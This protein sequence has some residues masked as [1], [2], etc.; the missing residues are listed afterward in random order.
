M[1]KA[2]AASLVFISISMGGFSQ[3]VGIGTA[4]PVNKLDVVS[5]A[6]ASTNASIHSTNTGISGNAVLGVSN[7]AGT[8]GVRGTSNAGTGVQGYT[9][10]V[11]ALVGTS[12]SG[13]AVYAQSG[14][15]GLI[16]SGKI[17]FSGGNT[18]PSDGALLTS[19]AN[20]NATWKRSNL[21]FSANTAVNAVP[22]RTFTKVEFSNEE[23]DTQNNFVQYTGTANAGSSVFT[24]PVAGIYHFSSAVLFEQPDVEEGSGYFSNV[25]IQLQLN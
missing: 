7:N 17:K 9:S 18:N 15:Y 23:F 16:S 22:D 4:T 14:G 19:D 21:A 25:S 1:K 6:A 8:Y 11:Y 3:N 12:L 2:I 13:T 24:A 20:G 5:T 10:T